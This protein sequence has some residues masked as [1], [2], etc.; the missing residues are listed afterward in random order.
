MSNQH[1]PSKL[2]QNVLQYKLFNALSILKNIKQKKN[3]QQNMNYFLKTTITLNVNNVNK[4]MNLQKKNSPSVFPTSKGNG[5]MLQCRSISI[6]QT[7][8]NENL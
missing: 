7:F 6:S 4:V 3:F 8:K 2:K 1:I 5:I